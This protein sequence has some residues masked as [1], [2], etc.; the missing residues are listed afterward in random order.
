MKVKLL[1]VGIICFFAFV[2]AS[3]AVN[4]RDYG[5]Q[6]VVCGRACFDSI[7]NAGG[8]ISP[9]EDGIAGGC[10]GNVCGG[11]GATCNFGAVLAGCTPEPNP[12][13]LYECDGDEGTG[14]VCINDVWICTGQNGVN[15]SYVPGPEPDTTYVQ[16]PG[17]DD[18]AY[19]PNNEACW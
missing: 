11:D 18:P 17:T 13:A 16:C 9:G 3:S 10:S 15:D 19:D 2:G 4:P 1:I 6:Q 8:W 12:C 14:E 7:F 5:Q